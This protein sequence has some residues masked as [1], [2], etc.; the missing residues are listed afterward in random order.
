MST[1]V[2]VVR[3]HF[4]AIKRHDRAALMATLTE[5]VD[6]QVVGPE[7][8]AFGGNFKGRAEVQRFFSAA[9]GA[10]EFLEFAA[11]RMIADGDTVVV[12]GHE[13]VRVKA[14]KR[15][16]STNWV[17]VY[18]VRDDAI[19]RFREYTD[20]AAIAAAYAGNSN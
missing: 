3:A 20:T 14:T 5:D 1:P 16:W 6:W 19:C 13:R 8:L 9:A 4:E 17:Q 7:T 10:C 12:L 18:T 2:D 15:E 11:D